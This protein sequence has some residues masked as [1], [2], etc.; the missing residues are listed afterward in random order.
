MGPIGICRRSQSSDLSRS[1]RRQYYTQVRAYMER[2]AAVYLSRA[3]RYNDKEAVM[4]I[5]SLSERECLVHRSIPAVRYPAKDQSDCNYPVINPAL[6][7][8][9]PLRWKELVWT[10]HRR[11]GK[12]Q[13]RRRS[14]TY[15]TRSCLINFRTAT[16]SPRIAALSLPFLAFVFGER[17]EEPD[18]AELGLTD[19]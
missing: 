11:W 1:K 18:G 10:W 17:R 6:F 12:P 15:I 3:C 16:E 19:F 14:L 9:P 4:K 8:Q 5:L 13:A 2:F 7:T